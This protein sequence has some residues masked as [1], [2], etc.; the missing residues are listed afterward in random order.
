[1]PIKTQ[2][3]AALARV[4]APLKIN[5]TQSEMA[6]FYYWTFN[7]PLVDARA[8][9]KVKINRIDLAISERA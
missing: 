4:C 3:L 7:S 6:G 1:M 2:T 5:K 8:E 9:F